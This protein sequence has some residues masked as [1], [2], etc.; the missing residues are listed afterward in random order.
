MYDF[1]DW[2]FHSKKVSNGGDWFAISVDIL[3]K[4]P[5]CRFTTW[6]LG[7]YL[8]IRA[9]RQRFGL[10][11]DDIQ[12]LA[13]QMNLE[14]RKD[15]QKLQLL[16]SELLKM[17]VLVP[18]SGGVLYPERSVTTLESSNRDPK[19]KEKKEEKKKEVNQSIVNKSE[20]TETA[21]SEPKLDSKPQT[22]SASQS[23]VPKP[24]SRHLIPDSKCFTCNPDKETSTSDPKKESSVSSK[25]PIPGVTLEEY[26]RIWS[27]HS[28]NK[29]WWFTKSK[30]TTFGWVVNNWEKIE[31]DVPP[32]WVGPKPKR[33]MV[34]P[35][36]YSDCPDCG[37]DF[38]GRGI[39]WKN[40]IPCCATWW[41]GDIRVSYWD[42]MQEDGAFRG[43]YARLD[44]R[45]KAAL[46]SWKDFDYR[47][48]KIGE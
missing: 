9:V 1:K 35:K 40:A 14:S 15:K 27:Y 48:F 47:R 32:D 22:V 25:D 45:T 8:R 21:K 38:K 33:V 43:G 36:V 24:C 46:E 11:T 2:G 10:V 20:K 13:R 16:V 19:I 30:E 42:Y 17:N 37:G 18:L 28:E 12:M 44:A 31:R 26:N 23:A 3:D 41:R 6:Q 29:S 39:R 5:Y 4:Q 34:K 7:M